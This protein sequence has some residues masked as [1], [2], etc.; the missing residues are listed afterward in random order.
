VCRKDFRLDEL[1][2]LGKKLEPYLKREAKERLAEG[3]KRGGT[4]AGNGR[5]KKSTSL[6]VSNHRAKSREQLGASLGVSG[7]TWKKLDEIMESGDEKLIADTVRT[8]RVNGVHKRL[9]NKI[10]SEEIADEPPPLPKGPFRVMV[11][12]PPWNYQKRTNDPTQRGSI[13]YPSMTLE[14]IKSIDVASISHQD[15]ILWL[16]T[17]NSHLPDAFSVIEAWGF[18]YKTTLTWAKQNGNR[19]LAERKNR[20]LPDVRQRETNSRSFKSDHVVECL[21]WQALRET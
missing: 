21:C 17:T 4:V 13:P 3:Q 5:K 10:A 1:H 2:A 18:E 7:R 8:G 16:W 15:C 19:R 11:V 6:V 12:D 9:K 20:A 14:E